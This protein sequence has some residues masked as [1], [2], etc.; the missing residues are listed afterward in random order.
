[1]AATESILYF[2]RA[3]HFNVLARFT[4]FPPPIWQAA[5]LALK[6]LL[7]L[8]VPAARVNSWPDPVHKPKM[9][10]PIKRIFFIHNYHWSSHWLF[11]LFTGIRAYW[12]RYYPGRLP[13]KKFEALSLRG[14]SHSG[15]STYPDMVWKWLSKS[16]VHRE[17]LLSN[18]SN[19]SILILVS[20]TRV[21]FTPIT[22]KPTV[23]WE[24]GVV[25]IAVDKTGMLRIGKDYTEQS[26]YN[27]SFTSKTSWR[28]R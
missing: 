4:M 17:I 20:A 3:S 11:Y 26:R 2:W 22:M 28:L 7:P 5:Q 15:K 18:G 9:T 27:A 21:T 1:M 8:V 6:I 10:K 16:K 13:G 23:P 24:G 12:L 19:L 14:L 25:L